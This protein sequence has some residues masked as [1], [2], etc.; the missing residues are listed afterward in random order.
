MNNTWTVT[1]K[2]NIQVVHH[3]L[4]QQSLIHPI[5]EHN[6]LYLDSG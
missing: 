6:E 2:H 1:M 3:P 4:Q 5:C